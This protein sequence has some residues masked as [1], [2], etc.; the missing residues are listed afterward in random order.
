MDPST[1]SQPKENVAVMTIQ[2]IRPL[3][4]TPA[5]RLQILR[6]IQGDLRQ[7]QDERC[8][9]GTSPIREA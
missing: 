3:Q 8:C 6:Q 5:Q 2:E 1:A 9:A 4:D 7:I